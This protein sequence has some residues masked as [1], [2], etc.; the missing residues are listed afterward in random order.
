MSRKDERD[1]QKRLQRKRAK[2]AARRAEPGGR[3]GFRPP[4]EALLAAMGCVHL[5]E[6]L[7]SGS[8]LPPASARSHMQELAQ[9]AGMDWARLLAALEAFL[10]ADAPWTLSCADLAPYRSHFLDF[11]A[12][13]VFKRLWSL[14]LSCDPDPAAFAG[15]Q[16]ADCPHRAALAFQALREC[17]DDPKRSPAAGLKA[18]TPEIKAHAAAGEGGKLATQYE[19]L[20]RSAL[21]CLSAPEGRREDALAELDQCSR[22]LFETYGPRMSGSAWWACG[23][24][25]LA[26][27]L[28]RLLERGAGAALRAHPQLAE[29]FLDPAQAAV[30]KA[31]HLGDTESLRVVRYGPQA[32]GWLSFVERHVDPQRLDFEQRLRF[33]LTRLKLLRADAR[34]LPMAM[35]DEKAACIREFL[36]VFSGLRAL[37]GHG[38]PPASRQT[39]ETLGPLLVDFYAEALAELS[40]DA[41][42]LAE[43]EA[44]LRQHPQDFRLGCLYA[45]G[46]ALRRK[47]PQA[48]L[49]QGLAQPRRVDAE[50]F[51]R[52]ALLCAPS[53]DGNKAGTL[54]R[55]RLFDPLDREQRKLCLIALAQHCLRRARTPGDYGAALRGVLP[56]FEPD[57]FVYR[58]LRDK[59][60]LEPGLIFLASRMAPLQRLELVLTE[61]QSQQWIHHARELALQSKLGAQLVTAELRTPSRGFRLDARVRSEA[62]ARIDEFR[63][64][65][66]RAPAAPSPPAPKPRR[67]RKAAPVPTSSQNDLFDEPDA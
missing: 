27:V 23:R 14:A 18:L 4:P 53:P 30:W 42:A 59:A 5:C 66:A 12:D 3:G 17:L 41:D 10:Y 22:T 46:A 39:A 44:L 9:A 37:L 26:E 38:V 56:Y 33:E 34:S 16:D 50:L 31:Q 11:G 8:G 47:L 29:R 21:A 63:P 6:L 15:F 36:G 1:R 43:T 28:D 32:P 35:E 45:S 60:A 55:A 40:A 61:S 54:I 64:P 24:S 51:A 20:L 13:Q 52:C 19:R 58:E 57:N 2:R 67:R 48:A 25:F 7:F 62:L 49:L 65:V